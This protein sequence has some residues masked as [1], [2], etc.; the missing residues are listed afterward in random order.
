MNKFK[1]V[2]HLDKQVKVG[3][4]LS[5]ISNL[6]TDIGVENLEIQM[7]TYGDAVNVFKRNTSEF[8]PLLKDLY[9]KQ[10]EFSACAN[11]MHNFGIQRN[12]LLD[13]VNVDSS[14]GDEIAKKK[15][16]GWSYINP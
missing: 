1:V 9:G 13:F 7:I 14:G 11:A 3:V 2:F 8:G 12:E 16:A 15:A 4:V 6:I 10:V 5:N